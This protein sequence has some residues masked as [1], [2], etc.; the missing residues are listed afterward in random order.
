MNT[1]VSHPLY[2]RSIEKMLS[3]KFLDFEKFRDKRFFITGATGLIGTVL[4][5]AL[6]S[7][8]V[9]VEILAL[10]RNEKRVRER[11][12]QH[13][14]N[15]N[16]KFIEQD[17][18]EEFKINL[19]VDFIVCGAS[20]S[21]S[22]A[23]GSDPAGTIETI[24]TGTK[25]T[26][27]L[28]EKN[29]RSRT[30]FLSSGEIYGTNNL[31]KEM[32]S[33][34]DCG[35]LDCNTVRACYNE[36]KRL[37]E[38]LFQ[39]AKQMK[40]VDFVSARP[41]RIFGPRMTSEDSKATAQFLRNA[42]AGTDIALKSAGTQKFSFGYVPDTVA[43]LLAVFQNGISGNVYNVSGDALQLRDFAGICAK[44][45]GTQLTTATASTIENVGASV[46]QNAIL[47]DRKLR[48][49]GWFPQW[50]L[51]DAIGETIEILKNK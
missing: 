15:A 28:A 25:N 5:D 36:A 18:R 35:Y 4:I 2:K 17:V 29:P 14:G 46:V 30:L 22:V 42:V 34:Q 45:A 31:G 12:P 1:I 37:S 27:A 38:C 23:Y 39:I 24:L 8:N 44:F 11:F 51:E 20:N 19:P 10:T 47:D 33:E 7:A 9:G 16:L 6:L 48:S 26:I 13:C 3:V 43:G 50:T 40:N 49:L 41:S 21:H 32:F